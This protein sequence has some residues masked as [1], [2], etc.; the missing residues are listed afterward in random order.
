[1]Y[2]TQNYY[3]S[4]IKD[5]EIVEVVIIITRWIITEIVSQFSIFLI[6]S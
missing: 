3:F 1:M 4:C 2:K 6:G 5:F